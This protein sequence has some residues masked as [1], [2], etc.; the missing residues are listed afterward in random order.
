MSDVKEMLKSIDYKNVLGYFAEISDI[1][2]GSGD[3]KRISDYLVAFAK[4]HNLKYVQD[5]ALN[6]IIYKD[7][8]EGYEAHTPVIIQ[9][10][11]DMVCVKDED[12]THDF[13]KDGLELI[14]EGDILHANKTT[15]GG[16]DGI[17]VAY[18]LALL[19]DDSIKHPAR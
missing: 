1:P 14:L 16:D 10:H 6:V 13:T 3:N 5:E 15:L 7:A 19:A 2:R 12:S 9:G 18:G 8:T 4:N 11:M 17:A